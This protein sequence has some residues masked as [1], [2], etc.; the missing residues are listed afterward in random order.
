[1]RVYA[2]AAPPKT[3]VVPP[4]SASYL[5]AFT[6]G[7]KYLE[8]VS[9]E[10]GAFGVRKGLKK[11]RL[12]EHASAAAA[13]ASLQLLEQTSAAAI[14]AVWEGGFKI[15]S[16][17]SRVR[18]GSPPETA[19]VPLADASA[20]NLAVVVKGRH[21]QPAL[22]TVVRSKR[23]LFQPMALRFIPWAFVSVVFSLCGL[24]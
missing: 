19:M 9:G 2:G 10:R 5:D 13:R 1:M 4:A 15:K 3:A 20:D 11:I 24:E 22:P 21:A 14:I 8:L 6:T 16:Q 12:L 7:Q 17:F 18:A 23:N